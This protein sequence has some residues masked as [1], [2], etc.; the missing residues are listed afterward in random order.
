MKFN[1][2]LAFVMAT[3]VA[4]G[5]VF[6]NGAYTP[7][8]FAAAP[9]AL[10]GSEFTDTAKNAGAD[11][12]GIT[13]VNFTYRFTQV[14][15][16]SAEVVLVNAESKN[17]GALKA[18]NVQTSISSEGASAY[19]DAH[20]SA[21][22][23]SNIKIVGVDLDGK[24]FSSTDQIQN[25]N[26]APAAEILTSI[27]IQNFTYSESSAK[28]LSLGLSGS[29]NK[30]KDV[31]EVDFSGSHVRFDSSSQN[32]NVGVI[33]AG[34]EKTLK[35]LDISDIYDGVDNYN[36]VAG[37]TTSIDLKK[38]TAL[39][40]I[41][42]SGNVGLVNVAIAP[43]VV[44]NNAFTTID[45]SGCKSLVNL[46]AIA[47]GKD[48][49][50]YREYNPGIYQGIRFITNGGNTGSSTLDLSNYSMKAIDVEYA[51]LKGFV[52]PAGSG[53]LTVDLSH[54]YLQKLDLSKAKGDLQ[55][56][57][58]NENQLLD[59]DLSGQTAL[60][61]LRAD[62]NYLT[63]LDI[64]P[65]TSLTNVSLVD[66]YI[67]DSNFKRSDSQKNRTLSKQKKLTA[68]FTMNGDGG[69]A[70]ASND[71]KGSVNTNSNANLY[72][73]LGVA[74]APEGFAKKLADT[75]S[76]DE[77][78]P[79]SGAITLAGKPSVY[80]TS[81]TYIGKLMGCKS[82]VVA[83]TQVYGSDK[84]R[85]GE[86]VTA[87]FGGD[88]DT[89]SIATEDVYTLSTDVVTGIS[90][91][92]TIETMKDE[93]KA[94]AMFDYPQLAVRKSGSANINVSSDNPSGT[95]GG[96]AN[97]LGKTLYNCLASSSTQNA[98]QLCSL[99]GTLN[100]GYKFKNYVDGNLPVKAGGK[101]SMQDSDKSIAAEYDEVKYSI[102]FS[103]N[104]GSGTIDKMTDLAYSDNI[105][106]P[107]SGFDNARGTFIGWKRENSTLS[108]N[109]G[110]RLFIGGKATPGV[111]D[112]AKTNVVF[113][114][115][116]KAD[117]RTI[118]LKASSAKLNLGDVINVADLEPKTVD[119]NGLSYNEWDGSTKSAISSQPRY[120]YF[121]SDD[122]VIAYNDKGAFYA[123]GAGEATIYVYDVTNSLHAVGSLNVTVA[124]GKKTTTTTTDEE[125]TK[126]D[127]PSTDGSYTVGGMTY[128]KSG[129]DMILKKASST[130]SSVTV[131]TV[132]ID[133]KTYKVVGIGN[134]AFKDNT[135]LKKVTIGANVKKIGQTAFLR[136]KNLKTVVIKTKKLTKGSTVG[137]N[138]FKTI[139]KKATIKIVSSAFT[140]TQ[141]VLKKK[142]GIAST[143]K[144]KKA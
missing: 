9:R 8:V 48:I 25:I 102:G 126:T 86:T 26:L 72:V 76:W 143:V 113:F 116:W 64:S 65:A 125:K 80:Y 124:G 129:N 39:T 121:T 30:F 85:G 59:I 82:V 62:S 122:S 135:T 118:N 127:T 63:S 21:F 106:L 38:F 12:S 136:C 100:I 91:R 23:A 101:V 50:K 54:N 73:M 17:G 68:A 40:K 24:N 44:E 46:S 99:V 90:N 83:S 115:M 18:F 132:K 11:S 51:S 37:V 53:K 27:K 3:A 15:A 58:V 34:N 108:E 120:G 94:S 66:N 47:S 144:V 14:N 49:S 71:T 61:T 31:K 4:A 79:S 104:G 117:D 142:A 77:A 97:G 96:H 35:T 22:S 41:D 88:K 137:K 16:G 33:L 70:S 109:G 75:V 67:P 74:G 128:V 19:T 10:V 55:S 28:K 107:K 123:T 36:S 92:N 84:P 1:R 42:L 56:L 29:T 111:L 45:I 139:H 110:A 138:A 141:K 119:N 114:A 87:Y 60:G 6:G 78:S 134:S 93:I 103:A 95:V 89:I 112:A 13:D 130:K 57:T 133:G 52:A 81:D 98:A 7:E 105:S 5:T 32:D 43:D 69:M 131:N 20:G 2:F 140:K